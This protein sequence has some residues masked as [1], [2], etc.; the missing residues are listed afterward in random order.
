M[1]NHIALNYPTKYNEKLRFTYTNTQELCRVFYT[2]PFILDMYKN[3]KIQSLPIPHK[4]ELI[5]KFETEMWKSK[6]IPHQTESS[7]KWSL[8]IFKNILSPKQQVRGFNTRVPKGKSCQKTQLPE[9]GNSILKE[10]QN[11]PTP[12]NPLFSFEPLTCIS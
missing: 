7:P 11:S 10:C 9:K 3:K 12:H 4:V 1:S 5:H 8:V 2:S 6:C